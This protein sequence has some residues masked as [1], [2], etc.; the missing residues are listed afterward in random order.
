MSV[1][2]KTKDVCVLIG[3]L[4]VLCGFTHFEFDLRRFCF[5]IFRIAECEFHQ[6]LLI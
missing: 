2:S 3:R 1:K 5:C 4:E 6:W